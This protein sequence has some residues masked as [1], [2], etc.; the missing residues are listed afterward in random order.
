M[1]N[2]M[3]TFWK[4]HV[5]NCLLNFENYACLKKTTTCLHEVLHWGRSLLIFESKPLGSWWFISTCRRT[6]HEEWSAPTDL[7]KIFAFVFDFPSV[8][9][10]WGTQ[11]SSTNFEFLFQLKTFNVFITKNHC[12][13]QELKKLSLILFYLHH[14][15]TTNARW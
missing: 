8:K 3:K 1:S 9:H 7:L 12:K 4:L 6:A 13:A 15:S 11:N 14:E 5:Q 2:W 10:C